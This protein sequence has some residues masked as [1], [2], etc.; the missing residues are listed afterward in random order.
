MRIAHISDIHWDLKTLEAFLKTKE[1]ASSDLIAVTGDL[2]G[3]VTKQQA[4]VLDCESKLRR[5]I[6]NQWYQQYKILPQGN[7]SKFI[8]FDEYV[9]DFMKHNPK[10]ADVVELKRSQKLVMDMGMQQ[11]EDIRAL[12]SSVSQKKVMVHG[13]WD[14]D[15]FF[16]VF[17]GWALQGGVRDIS[18]ISFFGYGGAE[19]SLNSFSLYGPDYDDDKMHDV[20]LKENPEVILTHAPPRKMTDT[21]NLSG[22]KLG[23]GLLRSY[24]FESALEGKAPLLVMSGHSHTYGFE[25]LKTGTLISNPG[26]LGSAESEPYGTFALL[27]LDKTGAKPVGIY[28]M[29]NGKV[30][31]MNDK[32]VPYWKNIR[33]PRFQFHRD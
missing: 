29:F 32:N 13:N 22:N 21:G 10:D 27:D 19:R 7:G 18:G 25:K 17:S 2:S 12:L 1:V 28:F 3:P 5:A 15:S 24:I 9:S 26:N 16:D 31:P 6:E 23:S 8:S 11:Y 33:D 4:K 14:Y 20:L 30:Y